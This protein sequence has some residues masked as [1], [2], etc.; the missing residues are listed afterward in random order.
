MTCTGRQDSEKRE[1]V[2]DITALANTAGGHLVIGMDA[3]N[4]VATE[5]AGTNPDD[6]DKNI[7]RLEDLLRDGVEPRLVGV[8]IC[9]VNLESGWAAIVVRVAKSWNP[10]HR[11]NTANSRRFYVRNSGGVHEASV[12]ELRV[13]FTA[14][15]EA[16]ARIEKFRADSI[17][18]VVTGHGPF[19]IFAHDGILFVHLIPLYAFGPAAAIDL[20]KAYDSRKELW[21]M[22]AS[23]AST[24]HNLHGIVTY[25]TGT[26]VHGYTQLFR[27]GIIEA[28]ADR[29]ALPS[30]TDGQ[31]IVSGQRVAQHISKHI[32][33]YLNCLRDLEIPPP[34]VVMVSFVGIA[35]AKLSARDVPIEDIAQFS[36]IEEMLLPDVMLEGYSTADSYLTAMRPVFDT[37]WNA[38]DISRCATYYDQDGNWRTEMMDSN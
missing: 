19:Y 15:A 36:H 8:R 20:G 32:P 30:S 2:K 3:P 13:L 6:A 28:V 33:K 14:T 26:E 18:K 5:L 1:A 31:K 34:I 4:G 12:E 17:E 24:R 16:R 9:R 10:P 21:P 23:D 25:R 38:A 11:V 35:N 7:T 37:L 22:G 29:M 27:N